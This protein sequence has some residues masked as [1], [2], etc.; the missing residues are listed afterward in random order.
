MTT[1]AFK[2]IT[3]V[4]GGTSET[5]QVLCDGKPLPGVTK[6]ELSP[7]TYKS[8]DVH[9][10]L[11][12]TGVELDISA[13]IEAAN[14]EVEEPCIAPYILTSTGKHYNFLEPAPDSI[15][16][17]DIANSLSNQ[18]RFTG[19]TV[20]GTPVLRVF[21]SVAQHSVLASYC[22]PRHLALKTLL[23]DAEEAYLGDMSTP[24]KQFFPFFKT[25]S[26]RA[27]EAVFAHFG[28][29]PE[30]PP[31]I[32]NA[33]LVLLATEKRDL[34]PEDTHVWGILEGVEPMPERI[35]PLLPQAAMELFMARFNELVAEEEVRRARREEFW[36]A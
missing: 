20:E 34:M 26:K 15:C 17:E 31:K 22:V 28:L 23:H 6:I 11:T 18:C 27:H 3:I 25:L 16:I 24:L 33:D 19:H 29:T 12:F 10:T 32:K 4:S 5:T 13:Q 1:S 9:A 36:R 35:R 8:D 14:D 30:M 2:G 21:Y 7:I